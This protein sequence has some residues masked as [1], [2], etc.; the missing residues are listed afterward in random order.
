M[1]TQSKRMA[2]VCAALAVSSAVVAAAARAQD[3]SFIARRDFDAGGGPFSVAVGDF[4]GDGLQDLVVAN[5]FS[6][7]VSVLL[8]DGDG[9]F[10]EAQNFAVGS[11]PR[12]V[13]VRDF[14]SDG[15]QDLAVANLGSNDVAVLINNTPP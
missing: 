4:N 8:G 7:D 9:A 1:T 6:N 12:S 2:L 13:A 11:F 14:N 3:V 5:G 10:Q 15:L